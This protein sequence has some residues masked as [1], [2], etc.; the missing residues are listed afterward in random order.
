MMN[1]VLRREGVDAKVPGVGEHGVDSLALEC[2]SD[3][4]GSAPVTAMST[5]CE[6][7]VVIAAAHAETPS[8]AVD[9]DERYDDHREPS[10]A[11]RP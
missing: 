6:G 11:P 8:V 9:A 10:G 1:P 5:V 3:E 7:P 4:Q 2:A